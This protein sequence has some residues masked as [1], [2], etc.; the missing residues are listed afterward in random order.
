MELGTEKVHN[1][2]EQDIKAFI[3]GM[4]GRLLKNLCFHKHGP[5][6]DYLL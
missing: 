2:S 4:A 3:L 1:K 6:P 5:I